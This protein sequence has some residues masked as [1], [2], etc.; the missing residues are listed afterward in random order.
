MSEIMPINLG[1]LVILVAA[2][3]IAVRWKNNSPF[4]PRLLSV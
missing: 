3:G 2:A 1:G 4:F